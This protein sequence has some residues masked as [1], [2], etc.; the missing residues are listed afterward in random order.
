MFQARSKFRVGKTDVLEQLAYVGVMGGLTLAALCL[1]TNNGKAELPVNVIRAMDRLTDP[2][3]YRRQIMEET[4]QFYNQEMRIPITV[5]R[6]ITWV[7]DAP[8]DGFN[9][10]PV[11]GHW[12]DKVTEAG[13]MDD[14]VIN[15]FLLPPLRAFHRE[16]IGGTATLSTYGVKGSVSAAF[17]DR[18]PNLCALV[19]EH[20]IGHN[21][22]AAHLYNPP[23]QL[24]A[25]SLAGC[26]KKR[27][28]MAH[29]TKVQIRLH[30]KKVGLWE[31]VLKQ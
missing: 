9:S 22:G 15:L 31:K 13:L 17:C 23:C 24:M 29:R 5:K 20:E 25:P 8:K 6:R 27:V 10:A 12:I 21:L 3:G 30:L 2:P 7:D 16:G 18:N 28:K 1:I 11:F 4:T 26:K 19:A 14:E